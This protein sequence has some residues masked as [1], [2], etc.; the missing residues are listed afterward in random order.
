MS[1]RSST[2]SSWAGRRIALAVDLRW[3]G[4]SQDALTRLVID[5]G[6]RTEPSTLRGRLA[7]ALDDPTLVVAY[8]VTDGPG[9]VDETGRPVATPVAGSGR[10]AVPLRAGGTEVGV[11]VRDERQEMDPLLTA[12][13]AQAAELA[14][15]NVRLNTA[16]RQQLDALD[17]S[18]IR[19]IEATESERTR[20]R[21]DLDAGALRRLASVERRLVRGPDDEAVRSILTQV[22]GVIAQLDELARGLGAS[23][24]LEA[25]LAAAL[26]GL[27]E[28]LPVPV[29]VEVPPGRWPPIVE[30]TAYFVASEALANVAKHA[31]AT[32][33]WLRVDEVRGQLRLDVADDGIGGAVPSSGSGL[34]GLTQRVEATGGRLRIGDRDGGGTR[35]TAELPIDRA[36]GPDGGLAPSPA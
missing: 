2:R 6:D 8:R 32:H 4:W 15:A 9:H 18:R 25:G 12:G 20:I 33:A 29:T 19:L 10:V 7:D 14:L 13:V 34:E 23:T 35:L 11:L 24:P 22:R 28:R 17:A 5:L 3:G 1:R 31:R 16:T 30:S 27:A 36:A 21:L 26:H